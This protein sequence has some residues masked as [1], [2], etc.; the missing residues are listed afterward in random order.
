MAYPITNNMSLDICRN[1]YEQ[2]FDKAR[3]EI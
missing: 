2:A 3:K 1:T